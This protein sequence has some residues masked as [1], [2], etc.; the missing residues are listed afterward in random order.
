MGREEGSGLGTH[1][2]LWQ[3]HVDIW[4]NQ[5]NIVK[6]KKKVGVYYCELSFYNCSFACYKFWY[7]VSIFICFKNNFLNFFPLISSLTHWLFRRVF[8]PYVYEFSIFPLVD[9]ELYAIVIR[10]DTWYDFNLLEIAK[11]CFL[12]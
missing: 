1:V 4:Q 10:E 11:V 6:F 2:Y 9:F 3:I 12:A 8:F 7:I 5:C